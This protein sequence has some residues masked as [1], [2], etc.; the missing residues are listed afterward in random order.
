MED[1]NK[2]TYSRAH[3]KFGAELNID[4]LMSAP[5][6]AVSKANVTML[7]GQ[8]RF[9]LDYCF[10]KNE[11]DVHKPVMITM[12]LSKGIVD[13]SKQPSDADYIQV[14][15]MTFQMPLLCL[16]PF[17]TL[18]ID[19]V[20]VDFDLEITSIGSYPSTENNGVM[21]R[22][23]VLNGRVAP[24]PDTPKAS[25]SQKAHSQSHL[26]VSVNAGTLPLSKGLL[27]VI[28]L[29]TKAIQPLPLPQEKRK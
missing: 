11:Q 10:A 14:A 3:P 25:A 9:L 22:K 26:K 13:Y 28:D 18:A 24:Q 5:L 27:T 4:S 12:T 19:N 17:N 21:D 2:D 1:T 20:K 15:E 16:L 23:A 7:T 29:Y 8:A 6:I